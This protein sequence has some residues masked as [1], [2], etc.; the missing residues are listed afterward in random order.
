MVRRLVGVV[1]AAVVMMGADG[2]GGDA[3]Q[4]VAALNKQFGMG[5]MVRFGIGEGG[6]VCVDVNS[7]ASTGR[8]YLQG[9][10]VAAWQ[11]R[12][13]EPVLRM[14]SKSVYAEGKAMRGG[15]PVVFPWF[16]GKGDDAKAPGHGVVRTM[17]W[18]V[19]SVRVSDG[20]VVMVFVVKSDAS[21]KQWWPGDFEVREV[22]SMGK[23]LAIELRVKNVGK[24]AMKFEE[25]LHS[26]FAVKDVEK[27]KVTGLEG[28]KY[29]DKV[30]GRKEKTQAGAVEFKGETDRV[31]LG[32]KGPY[33]IEDAGWGRK[34]RV[35]KTGSATTVVWN[36]GGE[37]KVVDFGEG[38]W[39]GY[40]CVEAANLKEEGGLV[41]VKAGEEGV[42]G[43]RVGVEK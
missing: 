30:D 22:V 39:R 13:E 3:A 15:V 20:A 32:T 26:Y 43:I 31:Y 28:V 16:A 6:L 4:K 34:V 11:P 33:V 18:E 17:N 38:D 19:E 41:E 9:G 21:T 5:E 14:S 35:E 25:A 2:A 24:E 40:V 1:L 12:G 36:V 42:M 37:K 10:H 7:G 8:V 27:V 29:L 23:E